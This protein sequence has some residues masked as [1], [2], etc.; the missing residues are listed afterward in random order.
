L[1]WQTLVTLE[2]LNTD[3]IS[4]IRW[5][6]TTIF[7]IF[8]IYKLWTSNQIQLDPWYFLSL[9]L[10]E[11]FQYFIYEM[12]I[13]YRCMCVYGHEYAHAGWRWVAINLLE[14]FIVFSNIYTNIDITKTEC[15]NIYNIPYLVFSYLIRENTI[16][17]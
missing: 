17:L 15:R 16:A 13:I 10:I 14:Y 4:I 3:S 6:V 8:C 1:F 5:T 2:S 9:Y 7:L 11:Q 12:R